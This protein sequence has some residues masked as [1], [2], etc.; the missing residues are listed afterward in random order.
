[1]MQK[2]STV[3]YCF[4]ILLTLS[5]GATKH[6]EIGIYEL[7]NGHFSV[8]FTN[9]GAAIISIFLPDN[10]GVFSDVVLGYD[11]VKTYKNDSTYFG[12]VVGRVANR[13]GGAQFTLN[14]TRYKLDANEDGNMLH[15][16]HRGFSDV[17]WKLIKHKK[18]GKSPHI[19]FA[20]HSFDGEE[21]F[22]G[23]LKVMVTYTLVSKFKLSVK[24]VA[25]PSTKATPVNLAQ[26][27]YWNLGGHNSG[28][29]LS[30]KIQI[31][32]SHITPTNDQ[33]IPTGKIA[34]VKGTP[35]DL[36]KPT[37]IKSKIKDLPSGYDINYVLDGE[38]GKELKT[39]AI[40]W[41]P[42]SKRSMTLATD[43]PGVQFYTGNYIKDVKGK[44]GYV[45]QAHAGLCLETQG[46][47]DAV[48]HPNFPSQ[49]VNPGQ[50]YNHHMLFT[51]SVDN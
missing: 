10:N 44:R 47:P 48:N 22:P 12:S 14:G 16:G 9:W 27:T 21:G 28:D 34:P 13:I 5:V 40:V 41:D 30:Q 51:F 38:K 29:I 3:F 8:K 19:T 1:M 49:I 26:H 35:Y 11:S 15:G 23:D 39:V 36:L 20:Y 46:F 24:M 42:K 33:L 37:V 6:E 31:F 32:A 50:T 43:A 17:V 4:I 25:R 2:T 18:T 7:N 45:Y